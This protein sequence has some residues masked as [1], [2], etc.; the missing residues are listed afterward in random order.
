MDS[1][2]NKVFLLFILSFIKTQVKN[3]T[4]VTNEVYDFENKTEIKISSK[5]FKNLD[6][7][8]KKHENETIDLI[9][10]GLL[11]PNLEDVKINNLY[12]NKLDLFSNLIEIIPEDFFSRL[13]FI[14]EINLHDNAISDLTNLYRNIDK[15]PCAFLFLETLDLSSNQISSLDGNNFD[16][17]KNLKVLNLVWNQIEI[18]SA[19]DLNKFNQVKEFK[20]GNNELYAK[21]SCEDFSFRNFSNLDLLDLSYCDEFKSINSNLFA[22]LKNLINI[23]L[24]EIDFSN[25]NE[26]IFFE[27]KN[28]KILSLTGVVENKEQFL[29]FFSNIPAKYSLE[30]LDISGNNLT[31]LDGLNLNQFSKL[32]ALRFT[33]NFIGK[34]NQNTFDGMN[35]LRIVDLSSNLI[36]SLDF[37]LF[38]QG[39]KIEEF[40][41]FLNQITKVEF[42]FFKEAKNLR[43]L[44]LSGNNL[45]DLSQIC[46]S[47]MTN[48]TEIY[49]SGNNI[50]IISN[51]D[52]IFNLKLIDLSINYIQIIQPNAFSNLPKLIYQSRQKTPIF[53]PKG[54]L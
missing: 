46:F 31:S 4:C 14:K 13:K 29:K 43:I 39:N 19:F 11:L 21:I 36:E 7:I 15:N 2:L 32:K 49:L 45:A 38:F 17:L 50:Y 26:N 47:C 6:Q 53:T 1:I 37:D 25:V 22:G 3:L 44:Y 5:N 10:R 42:D 9:L 33:Y 27:L 35:E 23:V 16:K 20:L 41:R 54:L 30:L 24:F 8:L 51:F 28:L 18:L 40:R 48:L 34:I 52:K 12:I